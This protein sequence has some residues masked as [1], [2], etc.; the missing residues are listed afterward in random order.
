MEN[1]ARFSCNISRIHRSPRR[2][3]IY[4]RLK[5]RLKTIT[6]LRLFFYTPRTS[7]RVACT[8]SVFVLLECFR[9]KQMKRKY[10]FELATSPLRRSRVIFN[11]S[12]VLESTS[13]IVSNFDVNRESFDFYGFFVLVSNKTMIRFDVSISHFLLSR[14]KISTFVKFFERRDC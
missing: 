4:K 6:R 5:P 2:Q 13:R 12:N 8:K 10:Q 1:V 7:R 11:Y 14:L 9:S 3:D